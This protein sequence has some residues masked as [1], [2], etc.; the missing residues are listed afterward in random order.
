MNGYL[1][2]IIPRNYHTEAQNYDIIELK[3]R[4]LVYDIHDLN[5]LLKHRCFNVLVDHKVIKNFR[6]GNKDS[7][8]VKVAILY[9]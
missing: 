6:K 7:L 3:L 2:I 4:G 1:L 8:I 5:K 9:F